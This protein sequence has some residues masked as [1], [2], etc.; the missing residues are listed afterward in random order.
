MLENLFRFN[1]SKSSEDQFFEDIIGYADI[2]QILM[3]AIV[4]KYPVHILLSGPPATA[5]TVFLLEMLSKLKK[6]YF[7]DATNTTGVGMVDYLFEHPETEYILI[8][9]ADKLDKRSQTTLYNVMETGILKEVKSQRGKGRREIKFKRLKVFAT[10]NDIDILLK[11]FRSRF[12]EF[13]L[14]EYS[15]DEFH[16]VTIKLLKKRFKIKEELAAK[17]AAAVWT[18]TKS[19]D[20][21]DALQIAPLIKD[22]KDLDFVVNTLNKYAVLR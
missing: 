1:F 11:P 17:I 19:K 14:P 13:A 8:D 7:I 5:K 2:K 4:S 15:R 21:R 10:G 12:M 18:R 20:I 3:R 9:E 22:E 6:A 16:E